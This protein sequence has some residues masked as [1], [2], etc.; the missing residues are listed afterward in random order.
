MTARSEILAAIPSVQR[1]DGT[2]SLRDILNELARRNSSFA[3]S[4][5][6]THIRSSMC[7]NAPKNHGTTYD[8]LERVSRGIYRATKR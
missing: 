7:V 5:L 6:R 2:F 1:G 8:D 4:T 3:E